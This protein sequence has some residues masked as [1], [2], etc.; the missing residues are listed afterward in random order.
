MPH[1]I[2][3]TPRRLASSFA[4]LSLSL[5][6]LTGCPWLGSEQSGQ[7]QAPV[8]HYEDTL[9]K[10]VAGSV[11]GY[12]D[13]AAAEAKFYSP[14]GLALD[15][16]GNLYVADT[17]NHCVRMIDAAG[18]VSTI[19][20]STN[21]GLDVT[22]DRNLPFSSAL[23]LAIASGST[24]FVADANGNCVRSIDASR[25]VTT[26]AGG[27][28]GYANGPRETARFFLPLDIA[29]DAADNLYLTES[30]SIRKITPQGQVST[31][32]GGPHRLLGL[33]IEPASGLIAAADFR[34]IAADKSGN[35]YV[36][37]RSSSRILKVTAGGEVSVL[38]GGS[39]GYVDGTLA[40]ARFNT[41]EDVALDAEGNLYVADSV[42]RALRKITPEGVVTTL[43]GKRHGGRPTVFEGKG[44]DVHF[45]SPSH[46]AVDASGS[47]FVTDAGANLIR[48]VRKN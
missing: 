48:V 24:V 28:Q 3:S 27:A 12:F 25:S 26:Y 19:A 36:A 37:D 13:G 11:P 47:L 35:V 5:C 22:P 2:G 30:N 41:P 15:A 42:N 39:P 40:E 43:A 34:G 8:V 33:P 21:G 9:V 44:A 16:S 32:V 45:G 29:A 38:A 10:T 23:G 1:P 14:A 20:G 17:G 31:L 6:L 7:P 18:H 46:L 4:L